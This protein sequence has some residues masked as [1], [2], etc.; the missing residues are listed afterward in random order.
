MCENKEKKISP[1]FFSKVCGTTGLIIFLIRDALEYTGII[2]DKKTLPGRLYRL[3]KYGQE[4][5]TNNHEHFKKFHNQ[6][7]SE[8]EKI[9]DPFSKDFSIKEGSP[10]NKNIDIIS[11]SILQKLSPIRRDSIQKENNEHHIDLRFI[12]TSL[13]SE[14]LANS[15]LT[16]TQKSSKKELEKILQYPAESIKKECNNNISDKQ[17][18]FDSNEKI[19]NKNDKEITIQKSNE[20]ITNSNLIE[21]QY[22][23]L[24]KTSQKLEENLN[25][26]YK[27]D[28]NTISLDNSSPQ[29]K[30]NIYIINEKNED[31]SNEKNIDLETKNSNDKIPNNLVSSQQ[32]SQI[33]SKEDNVLITMTSNNNESNI[34]NTMKSPSNSMGVLKSPLE[35]G[36]NK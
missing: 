4:K 5:I 31:K 30:D 3:Y 17:T 11:S 20:A 28:S 18:T 2:I 36:N 26:S 15:I 12:N 8:E 23:S 24:E 6:Y 32:T 9:K 33:I 13:E 21:Q 27:K 22:K 14:T 35:D 19:E 7:L 10:I 16:P 1:Q 34:S 29:N 25:I